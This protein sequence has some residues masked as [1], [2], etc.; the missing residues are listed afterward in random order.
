MTAT[1]THDGWFVTQEVLPGVWEIAEP[2][3]VNTWLVSGQERA[4]IL[5]T[6]LGIRPIRPV[7]ES[8]CGLPIEVVATHYHFDH[9]GGHH[10]FPDIA[11]HEAGAEKLAAGTPEHLLDAYLHTIPSPWPDGFG[12]DDWVVRP[13]S[14][15]RLLAE[16]DVLDL[17]GRALRVLHTPGHSPDS[18]SLLDEAAGI[19]FAADAFYLGDVYCHFE[20]SSIDDLATT[21]RRLAGLSGSLRGIC[22]HHHPQL[23]G[24][25]SLLDA[26]AD[27][28]ERVAAG[29][30]ALTTGQ[31]C[32]GNE[33]QAARFDAYAVTLP[34]PGMPPVR[35][36]RT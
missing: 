26:F 11:I 21:A 25:P 30:A 5:D 19:L 1:E 16:G 28:V 18:I 17:G 15:T 36:H 6:G 33:V 2:T 8:L 31:D 35:L 24:D 9:V 32:L 4:V 29:D 20:D 12:R 13:T 10:E 23:I 7:V 22:S 27:D 14:A 3:H 34:T